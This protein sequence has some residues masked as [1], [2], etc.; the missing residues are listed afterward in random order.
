MSIG[1]TSEEFLEA[2]RAFNSSISKCEKAKAK[3]KAD[4]PQRKWVDRQLESFYVSVSLINNSLSEPET[5]KERYAETELRNADKTLRQLIVKCEKL[6]EKFKEGS[7]QHTLA[8]RRLQ[9]FH[10]AETLIA[11]ELEKTY[12]SRLE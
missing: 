2:I 11:R 12:E 1:K 9:A 3:L 7:P 8:I 10:I 5:A 6:P 4:S